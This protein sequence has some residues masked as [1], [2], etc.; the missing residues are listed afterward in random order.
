M[1]LSISVGDLSHLHDAVK[2]NNAL[3]LKTPLGGV[4]SVGSLCYQSQPATTAVFEP[5]GSDVRR[6]FKRRFY[7]Q[8]TSPPKEYRAVCI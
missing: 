3:Q 6:S 2:P 4:F 5:F 1:D 7:G 8:A